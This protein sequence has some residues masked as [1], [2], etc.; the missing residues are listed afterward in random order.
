MA[1]I[2]TIIAGVGLAASVAGAAIAS[3]GAQQANRAS[4]R[5]EALRE[6]Q[7][8]IEAARQRRQVIRNML[9]ARS[10]ALVSATAQGA[11]G[12]SGLPGGYGAITQQSGENML[13]IN[14][15]TEIGA[16]IFSANR[17]ASGAQSMVSFG[18]GLSSL[19]GATVQN[20]ETIGRIGTYFTNGAVQN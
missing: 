12:G 5:A 8:N 1:A 11:G 15:G 17:D 19:G 20:S 2:S 7:M 6:K 3:N 13:G 4:A 9:R 16:G 18:N 10:A 14:Q